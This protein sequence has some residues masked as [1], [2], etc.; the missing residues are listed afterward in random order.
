MLK[1]AT[2]IVVAENSFRQNDDDFD[3]IACDVI[4]DLT[5]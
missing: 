3:L 2:V 5:K 4:V 1:I